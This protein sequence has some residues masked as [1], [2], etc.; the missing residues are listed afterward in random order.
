M[1]LKALFCFLVS[2]DLHVSYKAEKWYIRKNN[3]IGAR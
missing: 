2:I 3:Y 1:E